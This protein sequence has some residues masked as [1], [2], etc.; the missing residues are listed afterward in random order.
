[1]IDDIIA[2]RSER[3]RKYIQGPGRRKKDT[4]YLT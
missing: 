4:K 3:A 2:K 1:M